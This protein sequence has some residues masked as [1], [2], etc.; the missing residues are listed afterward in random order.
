[1]IIKIEYE[2]IVYRVYIVMEIVNEGYIYTVVDGR[3][4]VAKGGAV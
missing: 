1:M 2:Y 4:S 3:N